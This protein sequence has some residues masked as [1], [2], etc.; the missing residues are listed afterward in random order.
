MCSLLYSPSLLTQDSRLRDE[1]LQHTTQKFPQAESTQERIKGRNGVHRPLKKRVGHMG[2][3][4]REHL[5]LSFTFV[6]RMTLLLNMPVT[7]SEGC[8]YDVQSNLM[9]FQQS[10]PK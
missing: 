3:Q 9:K 2:V 4:I 7:V 10:S 8:R 1:R 5:H 6:C